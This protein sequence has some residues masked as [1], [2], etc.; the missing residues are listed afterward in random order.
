MGH[1]TED[2]ANVLPLFVGFIALIIVGL[3][4]S[5]ATRHIVAGIFGF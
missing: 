4:A 1:F 5:E 2:L 3:L